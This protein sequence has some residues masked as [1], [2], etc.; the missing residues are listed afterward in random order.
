MGGLC[1]C[2]CVRPSLICS[3]TL[4]T[5]RNISGTSHKTLSTRQLGKQLILSPRPVVLSCFG[6]PVN[7][8]DWCWVQ[9]SSPPHFKRKSKL[10]SCTCGTSQTCTWYF[11]RT[12]RPQH[13]Q[14]PK[15]QL[16]SIPIDSKHLWQEALSLHQ[17]GVQP[18]KEVGELWI[19][20]FFEGWPFAY[21]ETI[22]GPR[23]RPSSSSICSSWVK[24]HGHRTLRWGCRH[25]PRLATRSLIS[26]MHPG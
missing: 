9:A 25:C 14:H 3:L 10:Y 15:E 8:T 16:I 12:W 18:P 24:P 23:R 2:L 13:V 19:I 5:S 21:I 22:V 6:N 1:V 20:F 26:T 7:H 17:V 4:W 11:H